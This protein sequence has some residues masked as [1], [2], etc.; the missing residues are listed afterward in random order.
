M[1]F[2]LKIL[3]KHME[4]PYAFDFI[5][6]DWKQILADYNFTGFEQFPFFKDY[7]RL[8][9]AQKSN[10]D[11]EN[12]IRIAVSTND[13][14]NIFPKMLGMAKEIFIYETKNGTQ[15]KLIEKRNNP[16]AEKMQHLKTLD[17][18][19]LINDCSVIISAHIGKKGVKRLQ[20]RGMKLFFLNGSIQ[21]ALIEVKKRY[22]IS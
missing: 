7:V 16:F 2:C 10:V 4:C 15:F 11:K 12:M 22:S 5:E 19:D 21:E 8:L 13:G 17:V 6:R 1:P 20:E 3:F 9:K 14:I 18:Y